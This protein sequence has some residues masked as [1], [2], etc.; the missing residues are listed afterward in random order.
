MLKYKTL[1]E[2]YSTRV[3]YYRL[4]RGRDSNLTAKALILLGL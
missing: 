3:L 4:Q 2:R 1:V